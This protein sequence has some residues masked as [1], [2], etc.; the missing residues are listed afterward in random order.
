MDT[1]RVFRGAT[2]DLLKGD[3]W[4][5]ILCCTVG[6]ILSVCYS[7]YISNLIAY[8]NR[9]DRNAKDGLKLIAIFFSCQ[10]LAQLFKNRY[11][12]SGYQSAIK[13]RRILVAS[14]YQKACRLSMKSLK[15]TG[16]GKLINLISG[17]LFGVERG[18]SNISMVFAAPIANIVAYCF[19]A[20]IVGWKYTFVPIACWFLNLI[21][22]RLNAWFIRDYQLK[23]SAF[24]DQRLKLV[25]DMIV[26][27]RTIKCYG[28]EKHF[29]EKMQEI[30]SNQLTT[31]M[32]LNIISAIMG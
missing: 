11:V 13:M 20:K 25:D 6:E 2:Y 26:G 14:L 4:F 29:M 31:I 16:S 5:C 15:V 30:R 9:P 22:Q 27:C 3:L 19:I 12:L 23:K 21:L 32:K 10:I 7:Y 17:D 28:W 8:I 24:N 18:I 1:Y